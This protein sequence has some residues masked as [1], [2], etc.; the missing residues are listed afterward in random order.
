MFC[1]PALADSSSIQ[2]VTISVH[3]GQRQIFSGLG[4][5]QSMWDAQQGYTALPQEKRDSLAKFLWG[6]L[7]FRYMRLRSTITECGDPAQNCVSS[8]LSS[9]R[10]YIADALKYQKDL[11]VLLSPQGDVISDLDRYA[12]KFA[13]QIKILR[14][15]GIVINATGIS[16]EP[17][18]ED[19]LI[20]WQ[21]PLLVSAFRRQLDSLGLDDVKII[22][23]ENSSAD[24]KGEE[25]VNAIISDTQAIKDIDV[26]ATHSYNWSITDEMSNLVSNHVLTGGKQYWVTEASD[27]GTEQWE[28]PKEASS[29][30][31]RLYADLNH[32]CSVWMFYVGIKGVESDWR[33]SGHQ[34][35]AFYMILYRTAEQDWNYLLKSW[36]FKQASATIAPGAMVRRSSTN[37]RQIDSTKYNSTDSTMVFAY[38]RKAP[39]YLA[40]AVNQNG[41]WGVGL[42][43][44]T[45]T[46]ISDSTAYTLP[47][48]S[49]SVSV[50]IEEL[51]DSGN[52][53][54]AVKRCNATTPYI[55]DEGTVLMQNGVMTVDSI[56]PFDMITLQSP[57]GTVT[58]GSRNSLNPAERNHLSDIKLSVGRRQASGIFNI[59]IDIPDNSSGASPVSLKAFDCRGRLVSTVLNR[60]L[61]QGRHQFK[62]NSNISSSYVI[63]RL[64][65]G[66]FNRQV[67]AIIS[68]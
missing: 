2:N 12:K 37:L 4:A 49:F 44:Y 18:W 14:D 59:Q 9:Y 65:S 67:G 29:A 3:A 41:S 27:F 16:N 6:D 53:T 15:S 43:N 58:V 17:D 68:K 7:N 34:N 66:N 13:Q 5:G 48:E 45:G 35:T 54:F 46:I 25:F 33:M 56:G 60:N 32:L 11:V 52:I 63:F 28:D 38:G 40:A 36:Y 8:V 61:G 51:V 24:W 1:L 20:E 55:H 22:A 10:P 42:T 26:F 21:V 57:P 30:L 62:W 47:A 50:V 23:P 64:E 31:S 39:L 19:Q